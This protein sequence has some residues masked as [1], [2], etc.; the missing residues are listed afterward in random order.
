MSGKIYMKFSNIKGSVGEANHKDWIELNSISFSTTRN[1]SQESGTDRRNVSAPSISKITVSK[2]ADKASP[3][4]FTSSVNDTGKEC[5]I[6]LVRGGEKPNVYMEITLSNAMISNYSF[7]DQVESGEPRES[8]QISFTRME[9]NYSI[10]DASGK[11]TSAVSS[12]YD[13]S[14]AQNL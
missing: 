14:K 6:H 1:V 12:G 4:L 9:N 13:I 11:K 3:Y 10:F 8:M 2:K 7:D 5:I